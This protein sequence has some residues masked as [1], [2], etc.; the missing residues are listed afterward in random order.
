MGLIEITKDV[1]LGFYDEIGILNIP[2]KQFDN[3]RKISIML[4]DDSGKEFSIPDGI[5]MN[6]K[7]LKPNGHQLNT[8]KVINIKDNRIL[9]SVDERITALSGV[10]QCELILHKDEKRIT[11]SKFNLIVEKAVHDN[12]QIESGED[13]K[14]LL[15]VIEEARLVIKG[16]NQLVDDFHDKLDSNYF[17]LTEEKGVANGIPVLDDDAKIPI[18]ELYEATTTDKG[19]TQLSDSIESDSTTTAATSNSVKTVNELLK[20]EVERSK[21]SEKSITENLNNHTSNKENPHKVTKQQIELGNVDNTSDINKP[22]STAQ[23]SAIDLAYENSNKYTDL[24]ISELVNGAPSTLDTL[25]EIADAMS[26]NKNIVDALNDAVGTKANQTE[27]DTHTQNNNIHITPQERTEWNDAKSHADSTHART[28]ATKVETSSTNGNIK[29]NGVE[30]N[31]YTHPSGTNPHGTTKDDIGL[32]NVPNVSTNDQ[33]PTYTEAT[34]LTKISSGEKLSVAF[35]KISK[36]ISDLISHIADKSNP[37]KVTKTQLEL[38]NVENK[39]SETIRSELTKDNI[40]DALGYTPAMSATAFPVTGVKGDKEENYREGEVNITPENI[41]APSFNEAWSLIGGT[42]IPEN[43]DLNNYTEPGN[44]YCALNVVVAT[45]KNCP[46]ADAFTM[47]VIYGN[48]NAYNTQILRN[49]FTGNI[50]YRTMDMSTSKYPSEWLVIKSERSL[51]ADGKFMNI[52]GSSKISNPVSDL[53]NFFC[54]IGVFSIPTNGPSYDIINE[55]WKMVISSGEPSTGVQL[56]VGLFTGKQAWRYRASGSWG[57]WSGSPY[58]LASDFRYRAG[59]G[60]AGYTGDVNID[61]IGTGCWWINGYGTINGDLPFGTGLHYVLICIGHEGTPAVGYGNASLKQIAINPYTGELK[62]RQ[63]DKPND[64][65]LTWRTWEPSQNCYYYTSGEDYT[66]NT[67]KKTLKTYSFGHHDALSLDT[68]DCGYWQAMQVLAWGDYKYY[69]GVGSNGRLFGRHVLFSGDTISADSGWKAF[70]YK[71]TRTINGIRD[72]LSTNISNMMTLSTLSGDNTI[73]LT[74]KC[75]N[76]FMG[77]STNLNGLSMFYIDSGIGNKLIG[78]SASSY[79][80]KVKVSGGEGFQNNVNL[81]YRG[82]TVASASLYDYHYRTPLF[83]KGETYGIYPHPN[84]NNYYLC[85]RPMSDDFYGIYTT[86]LSTSALANSVDPIYLGNVGYAYLDGNIVTVHRVGIHIE[87]LTIAATSWRNLSVPFSASSY[88]KTG[89]IIPLKLTGIWRN[90][91]NNTA[92]TRG[93]ASNYLRFDASNNSVGVYNS[94]SSAAT[95]YNVYIEL[96]YI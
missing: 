38:G 47:K 13:Y 73:D 18:N 12:S 31:V 25:G 60:F 75:G 23:Q 46:V 22:V 85:D 19:I 95:Y 42:F 45:L 26:E 91:V 7:A 54:G 30:S 90:G 8:S 78:L 50:Y 5:N 37:H 49:F 53:N 9:L 10:V 21:D 89:N 74:P 66:G 55:D 64:S 83:G 11:T 81:Y 86:G 20:K 3:S 92:I 84:E 52:D 17:V 27:L 61:T 88:N 29:I 76:T 44:Y 62:V 36:A 32:N 41:G 93:I 58:T 4:I 77:S 79:D 40:T 94:G 59:E 82:Q 67:N 6:F 80:V 35:G 15:E 68:N 56:A 63:R 43:S 24:K 28:D 2:V 69:L 72:D 87:K 48:G 16:Y 39:D 14:D 57:A 70:A 96:T 1:T 71:T 65:W 51:L 34:A 33:T